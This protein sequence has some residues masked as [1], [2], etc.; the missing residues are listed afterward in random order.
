[1]RVPG[2]R[3]IGLL[4]P[5]AACALVATL[6]R[7]ARAASV[8]RA[9]VR[10]ADGGRRYLLVRPDRAPAGPRPLVLV[11]HGHGA[12]AAMA[13]G[14]RG[15]AAPLGVWLEIADREG[16]LVAALDGA[17]G[18]DGQ[19]GWNDCRADAGWTPSTDDVG[20]AHAVVERLAREEGA[21]TTRL[22]AMGMS[23]GG[24]MCFRLALELTPHLVAIATMGASMAESSQCGPPRWPVSALVIHGTD[25]P[26]V[27]YG[28]GQVGPQRPGGGRT[29]P[30]D[31]VVRLWCRADSIAGA[32]TEE[33]L[34]HRTAGGDPTR[35]TRVLYP[36]GAGGARVE[37]LRVRSGGHAEPSTTEYVPYPTQRRLGP[38]SHDFECAEEAWRFF[39]DV[40]TRR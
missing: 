16:L 11:L 35:T 40:P 28:G 37:L 6:P 38:Q 23:A 3:T 26:L 21:D 27:P 33:L 5:L 24:F 18:T 17:P 7:P 10:T 31:E 20:F 25:D 4:A 32:P 8:Q 9:S 14:Q 2:R 29:L 39:R 22:Y 12:S 15:G 1:M 34:P 13:L 30:I 36:R 19:Q